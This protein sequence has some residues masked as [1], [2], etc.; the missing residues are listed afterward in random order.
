MKKC[1]RVSVHENRVHEMKISVADSKWNGNATVKM[2]TVFFR[3]LLL[4]TSKRET[5]NLMKFLKAVKPKYNSLSY[6]LHLFLLV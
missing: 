1:P 5:G 2:F 3:W 4:L 6:Q